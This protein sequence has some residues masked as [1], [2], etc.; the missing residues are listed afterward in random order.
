MKMLLPFLLALSLPLHAADPQI[1]VRSKILSIPVDSP[2]LA[3]AGLV[4]DP[5]GG[6]Q[7]LGLIDSDRAAAILAQLS[8]AKDANIMSTPSV[9]TKDGQKATM[10]VVRE[11]I[12]PTEFDPGIVKEMK[13]SKPVT[14]KPGESFAATPVTPTAF[15]MRP[16]GIRMEFTPELQSDGSIDLQLTPEITTFDGFIDYGTPIKAA[17]ADAKGKLSVAVLTEN[18]IQQPVFQKM[19][20]ST[21]VTLRPGQFLLFGGLGAATKNSTVPTQPD[22]NQKADLKA[23]KP[24]RL[25]FFMIEAAQ[26][27]E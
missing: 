6:M 17:S 14:L 20:V 15:E 3:K 11:F 2:V 12:Y 23:A 27:G 5:A 9:T 10:E 7:N 21:S 22:L 4:M 1:L 18:K 13:D 26:V 25:Y 24:D 8:K 16:L 19:K